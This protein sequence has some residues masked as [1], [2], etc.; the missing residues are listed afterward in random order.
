MSKPLLLTILAMANC[1]GVTLIDVTFPTGTG[2]NPTFTEIDNGVGTTNTWTQDT[3]VLS[4]S[5]AANS[6]V[7]AASETMVAF[8][9]L[10][11][12]ALVLEFSISA[13][14]FNTIN[15]NGIFLGFQDSND[16]S[17]DGLW[18]NH[19]PSFGIW[20]G[21]GP[22]NALRQVSVGGNSGSG[23]TIEDTYAIA[24]LASLQDGFDITLTIDSNG[25]NVEIDGL[26]DDAGEAI[27]GGSETWAD[28]TQGFNFT[29]FTA[30][31]H[32]AVSIQT[33][34]DEIGG[35][36]ISSIQ[37]TQGPAG[38]AADLQI[39]D[40]TYDETLDPTSTIVW[41]SQAGAS[42]SVFYSNDLITWFEITDFVESQGQTT[43]FEHSFIEN[44]PEVANTSKLFYRVQLN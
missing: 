3:G 35:I 23:R 17:A 21:G 13:A 2:T 34:L 31:M 24:T 7:G 28:S 5:T 42:Y 32:A 30:D 36:T 22:V 6:T 27:T 43:E 20:I 15:A 39:L 11:S 16:S 26:L 33:P 1:H 18:N 19:S 8:T 41:A 44:P 10:G 4:T 9:E 40:F 37:L 38:A 12:D 14:S 29:N 25:W